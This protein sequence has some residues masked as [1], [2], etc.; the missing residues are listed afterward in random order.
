MSE[1]KVEEVK[2][3]IETFIDKADLQHPR[4]E[5]CVFTPKEEL[6]VC[7]VD[8]KIRSISLY[9]KEYHNRVGLW[10]IHKGSWALVTGENYPC[11]AR[12]WTGGQNDAL[13][14]GIFSKSCVASINSGCSMNGFDMYTTGGTLF[15]FAFDRKGEIAWVRLGNPPRLAIIHQAGDIEIQPGHDKEVLLC[16]EVPMSRKAYMTFLGMKNQLHQ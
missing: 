4:K 3:R 10:E 5:I 14:D 15:D 16:K 11:G 13:H 6:D 12:L 2:M 1:K 9:S 7:L 8:E